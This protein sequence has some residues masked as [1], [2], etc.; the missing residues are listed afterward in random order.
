MT[1]SNDEMND[2]HLKL[3]RQLFEKGN[4]AAAEI[5]CRNIIDVDPIHSAANDILSKIAEKLG[6]SEQPV[7]QIRFR[8]RCD[9]KTP[10]NLGNP[11]RR[12]PAPARRTRGDR[13]Q[14]YSADKALP[15]YQ[16]LGGWIL[17]EVSHVLGCLLL[18]EITNRI[19]VVHWG[20]NC[21]YRNKSG[22]DA[23]KTY[24]EPPSNITLDDIQKMGD[25]DF[26]PR[27]W[28]KNNLAAENVQK[29]DGE[30][31]RL[32]AG[33]FIARS[34]KIVVCDFYI[35]VISVIPWLPAR[36]P[37]RGKSCKEVFRY[38]IKKYLRPR[39]EI[40]SEC[41]HLHSTLLKNGP[42]IAVHLRGSD[43]IK[44]DLELEESNRSL[45]VGYI[46]F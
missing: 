35:G 2:E 20:R 23:F 34:E 16:M 33:Y 18:A 43:K 10:E 36:H 12:I 1:I 3:A 32:S 9:A 38:L 27:K 40:T 30:F 46:K 17:A 45:P 4:L 19:P 24:F 21:L 14:Q 11:K 26:F 28:S 41:T 7:S 25:V 31:S 15:A 6:I 29:W 8:A 42:Y 5:V 44:E 22:E 39:S 13:D 37:M